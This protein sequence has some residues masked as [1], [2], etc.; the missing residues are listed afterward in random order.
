MKSK[1]VGRLLD[2]LDHNQ[3]QPW[4]AVIWRD[5]GA[6]QPAAAGY[7]YVIPGDNSPYCRFWNH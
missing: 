1:S 2:A 5:N 4:D 6:C 7:N 3:L